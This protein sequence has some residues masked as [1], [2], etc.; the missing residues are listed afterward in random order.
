MLW[1]WSLHAVLDVVIFSLALAVGASP[2]AASERPDDAAG[3]AAEP[4]L[5]DAGPYRT[6]R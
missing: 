4:G 5:P 3:S 2:G 6:A 1:A